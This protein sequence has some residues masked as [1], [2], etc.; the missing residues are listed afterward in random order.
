MALVA[1]GDA[2]SDA[3]SSIP[4]AV[5]DHSGYTMMGVSQAERVTAD[6]VDSL[7]ADDRAWLEERLKEYREL[8]TY[9]HDH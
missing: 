2:A 7:D 4:N 8:L 9:L 3:Q 6:E 1:C 5:A